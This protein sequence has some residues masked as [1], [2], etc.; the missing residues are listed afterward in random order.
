MQHRSHS[1]ASA[2]AS[3]SF[4]TIDDTLYVGNLSFTTSDEDVR[5][6]FVGAGRKVARTSIVTNY[7]SGRSRG[8][9][10]VKMASIDEADAAMELNGSELDGRAISVGKG[11]QRTL[12]RR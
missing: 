4:K 11:R 7:K 10:F 8:F 1:P 9:A 12:R 3:S 6:F 2:A 5:K